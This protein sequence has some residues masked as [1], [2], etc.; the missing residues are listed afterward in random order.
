MVERTFTRKLRR[1]KMTIK[2]QNYNPCYTNDDKYWEQYAKD[3]CKIFSKGHLL[4]A[5]KNAYA[6]GYNKALEDVE[7]Q[8]GLN[9]EEQ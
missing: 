2:K 4:D 9:F 6:A 5:L 7:E 8:H 3:V 1:T